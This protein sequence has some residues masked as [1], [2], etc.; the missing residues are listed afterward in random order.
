M[1]EVLGVKTRSSSRVSGTRGRPDHMEFCEGCSS[2][3]QRSCISLKP[4][5]V[6]GDDPEPEGAVT[7]S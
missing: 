3:V 6:G 2:S 4:P 7:A 5:H 1:L